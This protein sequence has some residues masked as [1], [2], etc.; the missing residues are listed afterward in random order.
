YLSIYLSYL[1]LSCHSGFFFFFFFLRQIAETYAFLP[2]EAVTR[3][4][5]SCTE[6]QKRMHFNSNGVEPKENDSPSSLVSGII[7]YNMPLTSTYLKQ[8]KLRVMNSQEQVSGLGVF[9][10]CWMEILVSWM[11]SPFSLSP[12][13]SQAD[14]NSHSSSSSSDSASRPSQSE[15][16]SMASLAFLPWQSQRCRLPPRN[17]H[18]HTH[19]IDAAGPLPIISGIERAWLG[20]VGWHGKRSPGGGRMSGYD[21]AWQLSPP[22]SSGSYDSVKTEVSGCPEDLT[23]GRAPTA[24]DDDDD[25]DDHEDNDKMNDSEGMDPERLKAFNMFVRLFVDENLDRM[26][27][28]SKQPKEK[29]QAIIES[30]SRQFP[31]FQE[32]ARKRIRTYLKSCRRMKKNG[33]EM[34]RPTPP[35]LT[36]AMAENIL[37]AACES[38]TRKAAKRMR[39]EIYQTSQDEPVTLEK[40]QSRDSSTSVTHSSYSLPASSFSQDPVY[41][42]GS[43]NYSYRSYGTLGNTLQP[44]PSLQTGNHSNGPTDLS[45]KSG[46]SSTTPP[47]NSTNRG[48]PAAQLSPTEISAVRQLIAGYRE[49]AAFL[50]RSADELENLIL[51]QN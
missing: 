41:I 15:A 45:M 27:P 14:P 29:I 7:D 21:K 20:S 30:C 25:H 26:V 42:N 4:L 1:S 22:Y 46:T 9:L 32:R 33:M 31:E 40:Q 10:P 43:L 47:A 23:V 6:C 48:V 28:I 11:L 39:L 8:M 38:E 18:T 34:T 50:L 17:T 19:T 12:Q 5:M 36:S 49:S 3:F 24:D 13:S 37:A 44:T 2:R 16:A 35:H 51:Q